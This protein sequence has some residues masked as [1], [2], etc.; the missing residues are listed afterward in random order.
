LTS[1]GI[2]QSHDRNPASM[3]ATATPSFAAT[4]ATATVELTSPATTTTSGFSRRITG[5]TSTMIFAVC[6]A[7]DPLPAPRCASGAGIPRS[8]KKTSDI[9]GS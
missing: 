9:L 7:C 3:C 2:R 1:S 4:S 8:W 5:S 6:C